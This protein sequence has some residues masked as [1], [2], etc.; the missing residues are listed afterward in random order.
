MKISKKKILSFVLSAAMA[1]C[2]FVPA[3]QVKADTYTNWT[4]ANSLPTSSGKY[5]LL[6]DVVVNTCT[7]YNTAGLDITID[8]NG[9]HIIQEGN[10]RVFVIQAGTL[11]IEDN[12]QD[13]SGYISGGV[14][15]N[16]LGGDEWYHGGMVFVNINGVFNLKSGTL[17]GG[18][19]Y[20]PDA[21][22]KSNDRRYKAAGGAVYVRGG[23]FNMSGGAITNCKAMHGGAIGL[24]GKGSV[25]KLSL[26]G[27]IITGNEAEGAGSAIRTAPNGNTKPTLI[28]GGNIQITGNT[29]HHSIALD[30]NDFFS[31]G[32]VFVNKTKVEISGNPVIK[33]N[34]CGYSESEPRNDL[35]VVAGECEIKITETLGSDA[36]IGLCCCTDHASSFTIKNCSAGDAFFS[37]MPDYFQMVVKN[38]TLKFDELPHLTG[39]NASLSGAIYLECSI[40][41]P[42]GYKNSKL[43]V[44]AA[45]SYNKDGTTGS[46]EYSYTYGTGFSGDTAV[47]SIPVLAACMTSDIDITVKYNGQVLLTYTQSLY[48]YAKTIIEGEY[49]GD[50]KKAAQTM[51]EY[52]LYAQL[53]FNTNTSK[54]PTLANDLYPVVNNANG[55]QSNLP[56]AAFGKFGDVHGAYGFGG[57]T[58]TFLS[59]TTITFYFLNQVS[60]T[61]DGASITPVQKGNYYA[62]QYP[63]D[64]KGISAKVFD[65]THTVAI[66]YAGHTDSEEYTVLTYLSAVLNNDSN[67][68]SMKNLVMA[69]YNY[70]KAV[71]EL[72]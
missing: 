29:S 45:Y 25:N 57:A 6:Y 44:D 34:I 56:K 58:V 10:H 35:Y 15:G 65:T 9:N 63:A 32:A 7:T 31:G 49:D 23:E 66:S 21:D 41:V 18:S 72:G 47:I 54:L 37:E 14:S 30:G 50:S 1:M 55:P 11:T 24:E 26:T 52:G 12:S 70:A 39:Y 20:F 2:F 51:L 48:D 33:D 42:S 13:Q 71:Q 22:P 16:D 68:Q 62:Y 38:N 3:V 28:I 19:A 43:V 59:K 36:N 8:L 61:V 17:T 46:K 40:K 53:H 60:M 27:G 67:T 64:G 4:S 69:Y 5:K